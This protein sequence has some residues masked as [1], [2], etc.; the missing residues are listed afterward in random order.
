[1]CFGQAEV[2]SPIF[3]LLIPT[4]LISLIYPRY[5]LKLASHGTYLQATPPA[6]GKPP[7]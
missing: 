1:M 2:K 6:A 7:L 4:P 3:Q 5:L